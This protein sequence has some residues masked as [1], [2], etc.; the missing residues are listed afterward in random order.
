MKTCPFCAEQIQDE[1]IKC[2]HCGEMVSSPQRE[3]AEEAEPKKSFL[4][5]LSILYWPCALILLWLMGTMAWNCFKAEDSAN[6]WKFVWTAVS[7]AVLSPLVWLI[8]DWLRRYAA[9]SFYFG[10]GF[11]DMV[12]KRFFWTVGP[13]IIGLALL[14]FILIGA[15]GGKVPKQQS[16]GAVAGQVAPSATTHVSPVKHHKKTN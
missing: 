5:H 13:Q 10:T 4:S 1:A 7:F 9:P 15:F 2:R 11:W 8:A 16:S 6:G 3:D 14:A 12:W